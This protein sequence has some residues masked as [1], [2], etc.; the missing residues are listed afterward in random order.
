[1][2]S[3]SRLLCVTMVLVN[4]VLVT[5]GRAAAGEVPPRPDLNNILARQGL[6]LFQGDIRPFPG[7]DP[8]GIPAFGGEGEVPVAPE[9]APAGMDVVVERWVYQGRRERIDL[10]SPGSRE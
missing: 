10:A 3:K 5:S 4:V 2:C 1:V 8:V 9:A 7:V 6:M